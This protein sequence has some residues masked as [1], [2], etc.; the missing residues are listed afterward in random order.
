MYFGEHF[1]W[2]EK[3]ALFYW[4]NFTQVYINLEKY[5]IH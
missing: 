1:G 3:L 5:V 4:L 2:N